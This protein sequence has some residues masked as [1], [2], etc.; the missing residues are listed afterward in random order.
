M[1]FAKWFRQAAYLWIPAPCFRRDKLRRNDKDS[2]R[3]ADPITYCI[4]SILI[5]NSDYYMLSLKRLFV[6]RLWLIRFY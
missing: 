4:Y 6:Y 2:L 3:Y 1:I 5:S